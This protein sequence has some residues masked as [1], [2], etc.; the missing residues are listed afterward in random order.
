M[1]LKEYCKKIFLVKDYNLK[2][3][4]RIF[5]KIDPQKK[6]PFLLGSGFAE[7][8]KSSKIFNN[9]KNYGNNFEVNS[10]VNKKEFFKK[11]KESNIPFPKIVQPPL[12]KKTVIKNYK[13][14]GSQKIKKLV[15][16]KYA[17]KKNEYFQEYIEGEN[18]SI[19]FISNKNELKLISICEQVFR[20]DTFYID[21][22]ISKKLNVKAKKN[23]QFVKKDS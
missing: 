13:S 8:H 1:R 15:N 3:I 21:H 4:K 20:K 10:L 14:F 9:R 5:L 22:L 18:I 17:L 11:L 2:T 16:K 23:F 12:K 7:N 6:I 19:Q